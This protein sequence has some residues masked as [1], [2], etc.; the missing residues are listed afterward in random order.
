MLVI[1]TKIMLGWQMQAIDLQSWWQKGETTF[2]VQINTTMH[3]QLEANKLLLLM[4]VF[5]LINV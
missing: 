4:I 1:S 3:E 2:N 5:P